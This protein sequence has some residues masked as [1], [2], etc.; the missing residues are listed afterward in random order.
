MATTALN[1][2][3]HLPA[4]ITYP[5]LS[6]A[7][8]RAI[9]ARFPDSMVE[10]TPDGTVIIMPPT[11]PETGDRCSLISRRLGNWADLTKRG[12]VT[13]PDAGFRLL[14]GARLSP[15]AAWRD[16]ERWKQARKSGKKYPAFAPE[17]VIELRS[18]EDKLSALLDKM[19]VYIDGGVQLA[20]LIDPMKRQVH[21]YRPGGAT[22]TLSNPASVTGE[23][24]VEGFVL[25]LSGIF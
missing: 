1:L 14:N 10:Y 18:P 7:E 25:D 21:I 20:W 16:A 8:F 4:T 9:C 12:L 11:D 5:G 23:G 17:F 6:D 2:E 13:G 15:D 24:P 19:E 22:E 3:E